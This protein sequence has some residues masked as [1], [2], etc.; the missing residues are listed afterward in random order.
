VDNQITKPIV[1]HESSRAYATVSGEALHSWPQDLYLPANAL[2]VVI[3]AFEGPL[4]LLLYLI[5]KQKIDILDIPIA[6]VT[7]QYVEYVELMQ[8]L[9]LDL[10]AEYLVMAAMLAEIKSRMLIPRHEVDQ[11]E[12]DPRAVLVRRLQEY[13]RFRDAATQLDERP[14]LERELYL[15]QARIEDAEP[16]QDETIVDLSQL[17]SAMR[18]AILRVDQRRNLQLVPETLSVRDRMNQVLTRVRSGEYVRIEEFFSVDEGR[19][20]LIVS[21]L[22]VLELVRDRLLVVVQTEPFSPIHVKLT[23]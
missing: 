21:F 22:A 1:D 5:R 13:E 20:G 8:H 6:Q 7:H 18:D 19:A 17:L 23:G 2:E 12:E 9:H 3:E 4:D 15:V 10:A 16:V 11:D 14:R